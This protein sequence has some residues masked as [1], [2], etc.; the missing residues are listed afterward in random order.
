MSAIP[1]IPDDCPGWL[2]QDDAVV[3]PCFAAWQRARHLL[4]AQVS[5]QRLVEAYHALS[6]ARGFCG[7]ACLMTLLKVEHLLVVAVS[8]HWPAGIKHQ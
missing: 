8:K 7:G 4:S 6:V 5:K 3:V 1:A 2:A